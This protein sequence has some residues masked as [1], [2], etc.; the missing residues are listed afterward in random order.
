MFNIKRTVFLLVIIFILTACSKNGGIVGTAASLTMWVVVDS[1][2][3]YNNLLSAYKAQYPNIPIQIT[4]FRL[5]DYENELLNALAEDRGPDIFMIHNTWLRKYLPKI[6]PLPSQITVP[7]A[8]STGAIK[9]EIIIKQVTS[10]TPTPAAIKRDFVDVVSEDVVVDNKIY[11]LPLYLDSLV[12][13]YNRDIL[14]SAGLAQPPLFWD[15][16]QNM[17]QQLTKINAQNEI[18]QSGAALGTARNI[19][20]AQDILALLMMQNGAIMTN[21]QKNRALFTADAKQST[22]ESPATEALRFYT[23]FA[24]PQT[25][26]YSWNNKQT[27]NLEAFTSGRLAFFFGYAYHLPLIKSQTL[28]KLNFGASPMLQISGRAPVNIANYFLPVVAKKSKNIDAAWNF[29]LFATKAE[30]ANHYL[31]AVKKPTALRAL[32]EKEASNEDL[33][34]HVK[35]SLTAKNWYYGKNP[36]LLKT[37]VNNLIDQ[38]L[39]VEPGPKRISELSRL[40]NNAIAVIN[41]SY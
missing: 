29:I 33:F 8:V 13:Y 32:V 31:N 24:L 6:E 21:E 37:A 11:G 41:Q 40:L 4:K 26:A 18:I 34:A 30:N 15:Q 3:D 12:L 19:D 7:Q 28:G 36:D 1:P 17:S 2:S 14:N 25:T 35:Q 20:N 22:T 10:S 23:D 27:N 39:I 16:F 38:A 9:K 5:E